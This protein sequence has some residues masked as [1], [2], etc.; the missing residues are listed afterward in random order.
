MHSVTQ[1]NP[2]VVGGVDA[3]ADT[4]QVA[5]L[6]DRGA[7]LGTNGFPATTPGYR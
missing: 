2:I 7:L 5:A 4:H 6:D 3:D 1:E